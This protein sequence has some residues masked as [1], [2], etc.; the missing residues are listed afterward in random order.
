MLGAALI[1]AVGACLVA[2]IE[3]LSISPH[4]VT[5][6]DFIEYW[7]IGQQLAHG[8]NPY[9][10][11][12]ILVLEQSTEL[13]GAQ[14]RVS[15]SPPAVLWPMLPLGWMNARTG[16]VFW[17]LLLL[18]SLSIANWLM[19]R[20]NGRPDNLLH[21]LGYVYA[22]AVVCLIAGQISIFLL[23][24]VV[25]F[26]A[27][28][29]TRPALAGATL[30]PCLLKPHLFLVVG[31]VLVIWIVQ[32][33]AW[34][35]AAG[36]A[37]ATIASCAVSLVFDSHIW[38]QYFAMMH[39]ARVVDWAIPSLGVL[40]RRLI[41]PEAAWLQFVPAVAGGIWAVVYY[42]LRRDRWEWAADGLALLFV[43]VVCAPYAFF[44]DECLLLPLVLTGLYQATRSGRSWVPIALINAAVLVEVFGQV[45]INSP[46]YLWTPFAWFG[47]Y[48]YATHDRAIEHEQTGQ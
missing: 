16:F 35:V 5:E 15:L 46:W 43:T 37:A 2:G 13:D 25:L 7:A 45:N 19:W 10:A 17:S 32:R 11:H 4:Q 41:A 29:K 6:R 8:G 42:W 3:F 24:G 1:V 40:L 26:L 20:L 33:K 12:A 48:V 38:Q 39:Q 21:L 23:L 34:R 22:P 36:F 47:W 18:G 31:A 30:L 44:N 9:D 28:H 14:L 27:W